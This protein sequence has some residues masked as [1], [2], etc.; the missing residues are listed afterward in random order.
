MREKP[1]TETHRRTLSTFAK[2]GGLLLPD[3][4]SLRRT[5]SELTRM[6]YLCQQG[7]LDGSKR[8]GDPTAVSVAYQITQSGIKAASFCALQEAQP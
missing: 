8:C 5:C 3:T 4:E 7:I 6:G 1:L 2:H